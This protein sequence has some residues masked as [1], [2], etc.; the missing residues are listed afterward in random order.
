M[1]PKQKKVLNTKIKAQQKAVDK[2]NKIAEKADAKF[3]K[4]NEKL[5]KLKSK[6]LAV[7]S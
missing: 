5:S 7:A 6:L 2:L 4:A 1:S 3:Q